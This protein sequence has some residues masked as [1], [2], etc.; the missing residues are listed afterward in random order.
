MIHRKCHRRLLVAC[1]RAILCNALD[2][3]SITSG[4][5]GEPFGKRTAKKSLTVEDS[6]PSSPMKIVLCEAK[7]LL[8]RILHAT[9]GCYLCRASQ[10][11]IDSFSSTKHILFLQSTC[12]D[13]HTDWHTV[14]SVN[15]E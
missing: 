11:I 9:E 8:L 7:L 10:N 14:H 15:I 2:D 6:D 1:A 13:L 12:H 5:S 3:H 4:W